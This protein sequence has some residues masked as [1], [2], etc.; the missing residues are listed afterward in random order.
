MIEKL[1]DAKPRLTRQQLAD[2]QAT[3]PHGDRLRRAG[4][5]DLRENHVVEHTD[6]GYVVFRAVDA[7]RRF[8]R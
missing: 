5:V 6:D 2:P 7:D 4:V 1:D 3:V 8:D